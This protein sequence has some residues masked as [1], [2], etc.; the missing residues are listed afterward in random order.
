MN[1][2]FLTAPS[3]AVFS[4]SARA[5]RHLIRNT[6][7]YLFSACVCSA[8]AQNMN[9][10]G[11]FR[12]VTNGP[13]GEYISGGQPK[14]FLSPAAEQFPDVFDRS[15]PTG[16]DYF[17]LFVRYGGSESFFIDIA[18]DGLNRNLAP[19]NYP[20]AQRA[21]FASSGHPGLDVVMQGRG[22]NEVSGSFFIHEVKI[23][24][25]NAV[26]FI[27]VSFRQLCEGRE[28]AL[29]GRFTYSAFGLPIQ[30]RAPYELESPQAVPSL[31]PLQLLFLGFG[32][33]TLAVLFRRK[34]S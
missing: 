24:S 7:V 23:A 19:G 3:F 12:L 11:S 20:D 6:I 2:T 8:L 30:A 5:A 16:T 27:D 26:D 14:L 13:A 4:K 33:L 29:V 34:L 17:R 1:F 31:E 28:P 25:N 10:A 21:S 15:A 22:C 9:A 32:I 18:T